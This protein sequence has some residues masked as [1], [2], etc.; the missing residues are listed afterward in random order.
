MTD[1]N[2]AS[3]LAF[4]DERTRPARDLL[5]QV[6]LATAQRVY[7]LGCG[8]GNSTALLVER[9]PAAQVTGIDNSPAMLD[10]ARARTHGVAVRSPKRGCAPGRRRDQAT[11]D[12]C[13]VPRHR[14]MFCGKWQAHSG[15]GRAI[16]ARP[17]ALVAS[18][19]T[20]LAVGRL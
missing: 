9:F 17:Q 11:A 6:P 2:P 12:A 7:D 19:L 3:Y 10:A 13:G 4:A 5:A 18:S 1:W 20:P 14:Y 16:S 15:A 8:P